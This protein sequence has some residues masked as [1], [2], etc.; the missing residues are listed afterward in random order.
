MVKKGEYIE[1]ASKLDIKDMSTEMQIIIELCIKIKKL[2]EKIDGISR[3]V[4]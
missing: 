2:E 1:F 4:E 3:K